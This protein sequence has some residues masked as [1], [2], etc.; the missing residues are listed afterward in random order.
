MEIA[1]NF[2]GPLATN[3]M[4]RINEN[5]NVVGTIIVNCEGFPETTTLDSL[6]A[7][8]YSTHM[9][10]LSH[11]A[12][13]ALKEICGKCNKWL[14]ALCAGLTSNQLITLNSTEAIDWKC[15]TCAEG[16]KSRRL[17]CIM[18]DIEDEGD[19]NTDPEFLIPDN[20]MTQQILREIRNEI[21]DIV[22]FELQRSL[23]Y[24]SDKID[25]YEERMK[26]YETRI[27]R[28]K[29]RKCN[30]LEQAQLSQQL[31]V[32]GVKEVEREDTME[33]IKNVASKINTDISDVIKAYRK[34]VPAHKRTESK[35]IESPHNPITVIL[36]NGVRSAWL[37]AS[38]KVKFSARDIGA[39]G[40]QN[41]YLRESLTP[42]TAYLLWKTKSE[43]KVRHGF[44]YVWC[45]NGTVLARKSENEKI[46]SFHSLQQLEV[47]T[48]KLEQLN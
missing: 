37:E 34:K 42:A 15:R 8:T 17:S 46:I 43:L 36:R 4:R 11:H 18:P 41:L 32:C 31:E 27:K 40:E 14:H 28:S 5:G 45:K 7:A 3:T 39:E 29:I 19:D 9:R 20:N 33:I 35:R 13:N 16:T 44:K 6:T 22:Q 30:Q 10:N 1:Q 47:H 38:K 21:K 23:K 24:Y 26:L 48:R 2:M 25:D 12:S